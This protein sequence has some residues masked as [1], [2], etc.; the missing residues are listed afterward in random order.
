M[1]FKNII[2]ELYK[3][4][5]CSDNNLVID[6][7]KPQQREKLRSIIMEY[8]DCEYHVAEEWINDAI[9]KYNE[10]MLIESDFTRLNLQEREYT[11]A[12]TR[13]GSGTDA[14]PYVYDYSKGGSKG[15]KKKDDSGTKKS[16]KADDSVKKKSSDDKDKKQKPEKEE[17][18]GKKLNDVDNK[19]YQE[20]VDPSEEDYQKQKEKTG[21]PK[22]IKL[23]PPGKP[24]TRED[25][26]KHFPPGIPDKYKDV[27]VRLLNSQLKKP[28]LK[29]NDVMAG[30]G[31]GAMPAQAAEIFTMIAA[32]M[33]DEQFEEFMNTIEEHYEN[34]EQPN[35][36]DYPKGKND[37]KFKAAQKAAEPVFDQDWRE[38]IRGARA[39]I[40]E[41]AAPDEVEFCAWD[42]KGDVEAMGLPYG[43]K[44]FSTDVYFRTKSGK[45]IEVSLKKDTEVMLSSP[46]AGGHVKE[47]ILGVTGLT[48]KYDAADEKYK[49]LKK[50][51][52]KEDYIEEVE[53]AEA[54]RDAI[55]E[56]ATDKLYGKDNPANPF[57]A[58]R[59]QNEST[60]KIMG[61]MDENQID[62]IENMSD[63]DIDEIRNNNKRDFPEKAYP[64]SYLRA[65]RDLIKHLKQSGYDVPP[66]TREQFNEVMDPDHPNYNEDIKKGLK[67][68]TNSTTG[69]GGDK[70]FSKFAM[71]SNKLLAGSGDEKAQK[72]VD[73]H[74][75]ITDEFEQKYLEE[76]LKD[77]P[78]GQEMRKA[79]M[80]L[81]RKKFPLKAMM[82]GE[83]VMAL[84]GLAGSP[85]VFEDMFGKNPDTGKPYTYDELEKKLTIKDNKLVFVAEGGEEIDVCT[86]QVRNKGRGYNNLESSTLEMKIPDSMKRRIYCSNVRVARKKGKSEE[87]F[88]K[89]LSTVET[90]RQDKLAKEFGD[91]K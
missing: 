90:K 84:G 79:T 5:E 81:I 16:K 19:H 58:Q 45:L 87:E 77:T 65:S 53:K 51:K 91:C 23:K 35:P 39:T 38:S 72:S 22:D 30:V 67:I 64:A 37:P 1:S 14:D 25:I 6:F 70:F 26:E 12:G 27:M 46:S 28:N 9:I 31:A 21:R 57:H 3:S 10:L 43:E 8:Y 60:N 74:L 40:R 68:D 17:S 24:L 47:N 20:D 71:A 66:I 15:R 48:K 34:I 44:G 56:E 80:S 2:K 18:E 50:K 61:D 63:D 78:A 41:F 88:R 49:K 59:Q 33:S 42:T 13:T 7:E 86:F 82:E 52:P 11:G 54:E 75:K 4:D 85:E 69:T 29:M 89:N 36:D 73:D 83:E 62:N 32:T 55:F 76:T